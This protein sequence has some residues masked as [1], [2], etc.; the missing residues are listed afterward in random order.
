MKYDEN[1][2]NTH[3]D[4]DNC[5]VTIQYTTYSMSKVI[6]VVQ[7][8]SPIQWSTSATIMALHYHLYILVL[9]LN[10]LLVQIHKC[11]YM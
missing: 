3:T 7:S 5:S 6:L 2:H 4:S 9:H 10:D 11:K 1:I 8:C